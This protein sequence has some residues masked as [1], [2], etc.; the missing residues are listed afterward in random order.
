[1]GFI[2]VDIKTIGLTDNIYNQII[3]LYSTFKEFN[4]ADFTIDR[5][6]EIISG[7][8]ENHNIFLYVEDGII[9]GGITL[10]VEQKLIHDGQC[11]GHIEDFVVLEKYRGEQIGKKLLEYVVEVSIQ[12]DCYKCILD[13][14]SELEGYYNTFGFNNRGVYMTRI[15]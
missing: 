8:P 3:H 11:C 9:R 4:K 7:L 1:M 15:L 2:I 13:C 10:F 6:S 5:L 12:N 14:D